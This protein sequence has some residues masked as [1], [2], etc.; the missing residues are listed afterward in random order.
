MTH[1]LKSQDRFHVCCVASSLRINGIQLSTPKDIIIPKDISVLFAELFTNTYHLFTNMSK[2]QGTHSEIL[3]I[4]RVTKRTTYIEICF[5]R[6]RKGNRG[7]G[8]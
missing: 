5:E 2:S 3:T 1:V 8:R 6:F 7:Y 4:H